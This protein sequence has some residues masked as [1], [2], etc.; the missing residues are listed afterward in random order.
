MYKNKQ[1]GRKG[2]KW[3]RIFVEW[4]DSVKFKHPWWSIEDFIEENKNY[5]I[6]TSIGY[7]FHEDKYFIYIATSMHWEDG[8]VVQFGNITSIPKAAILKTRAI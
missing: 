1:Q 6:M 8:C 4:I 5:S 7:K 3:N 2:K